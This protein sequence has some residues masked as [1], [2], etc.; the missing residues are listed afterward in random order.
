M[1][2]IILIS[3]MFTVGYRGIGFQDG[4]VYVQRIFNMDMLPAISEDKGGYRFIVYRG[5]INDP[6][7]T[8]WSGWNVRVL[9]EVVNDPNNVVVIQRYSQLEFIPHIAE[10]KNPMRLMAELSRE[11]K[12]KENR[13]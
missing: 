2:P 3:L 10:S 13:K 11:W 12:R 7:T 9:R 4:G 1:I 5:A 6:N 8:Y